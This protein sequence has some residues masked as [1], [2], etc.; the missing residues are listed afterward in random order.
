MS[1]ISA[2]LARHGAALGS[3]GAIQAMQ[4]LL[5][6]L[7]LP[8]LARILGPDAFGLLM[9]MCLIPPLAALFVDWGLAQGGA[10]AAARMRGD[11]EGL[12]GLLGAALGS[13][14]F[15]CGACLLLA[16]V[17]Q[18][19]IPHAADYP[20]AWFLA[21]LAGV[22][23]GL[24]P[25][26]FFQGAGFGLPLAA[27]LD[28]AASGLVLALTLIFI[29]KPDEWPLYLFFLAACK[30]GAYGCLF[31]RLWRKFPPV[32][33]RGAGLAL[34][35]QTT[36]FS[37]AAVSLM[38]CY[39][40]SQL[41]L[42]YFLSAADMGIIGAVYKM[43]RA[44]V[45][46]VN[47]F[48]QTLFP[49]LCILGR[50][51]P[52]RA[53]KIMR[54]SLGWTAICASLCALLLWTLAPFLTRMALGPEYEAA[55]RVLRLALLAAPLMALNNVLANQILAPFGLE[56]AQLAV[57]AVCALLGLPLAAALASL[58]GISGGALLPVCLE[59]ALTAGFIYSILRLRPQALSVSAKELASNNNQENTGRRQCRK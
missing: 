57:Q 38:F 49:E 25:T 1:G 33:R 51:A 59:A 37:G 39:N 9:Y 19:I 20:G 14:I 16:V 41:A 30:C 44:A 36:A 32:F 3:F 24:N 11:A 8:W 46:L 15:L 10:R 21:V 43:L 35:G 54:R 6:L 31:W 48:T 13:K 29:R 4:I 5:P 45:S 27:G 40:G 55:G 22:G 18:P 53:R 52:E 23:R 17:F 34:L 50:D 58:L 7:A 47:P 56:K 42:G 26:W 28:A 2:F 12:A